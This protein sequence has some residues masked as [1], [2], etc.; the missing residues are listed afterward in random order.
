MIITITQYVPAADSSEIAELVK[1]GES[2][3]LNGSVF[4]FAPLP[5][6]ASLPWEAIN[7]NYFVGEVERVAGEIR[8][9]LHLPSLSG[10]YGPFVFDNP[11]DGPIVVGEEQ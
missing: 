11:P 3:V 9:H 5:D 1:I 8:A 4:D 7:S 6:G 2:L 10:E